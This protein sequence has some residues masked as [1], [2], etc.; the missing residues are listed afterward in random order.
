MHGLREMKHLL[1]TPLAAMMVLFSM[2][3]GPV[4]AGLVSTEQLLDEA[5]QDHMM[6]EVNAR[7]RVQRFF[8][9]QDVRDE[10]QKLGVD[11]EEALARAMALSDA[12]IKQISGKLDQLPAGGSVVGPI[13]GAAVFIFVVLLVTD[14]LCFTKV[15]PFTK[16]IAK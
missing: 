5:D 15:F 2:S 14:F 3:A 7:D 10:L 11:P 16:C 12:E 4:N 13:V 6:A 8:E 1:V 9:R